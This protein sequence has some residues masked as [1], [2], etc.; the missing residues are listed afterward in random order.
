MISMRST[1]PSSTSDGRRAL[2]EEAPL[3]DL[4]PSEEQ[5]LIVETVHQFAENEVR[6]KARDCDES[7]KLPG[8]VLSQAHELGLVANALDEA[9]GGGGERSAVTAAL[10]TEE[11]AGGDLAIALAALSPALVALPVSDFGS[12]AQKQAILPAFTGDRFVPGSLA[13]LEPEFGADPM[14]PGT[15]ARRDGGDFVLDGAKCLVPWIEG[16]THVIVTATAESGPRAFVVPCEALEVSPERV[17]QLLHHRFD[18]EAFGCGSLHDFLPGFRHARDPLAEQF[19]VSSDL[20]PPKAFLSRAYHSMAGICGFCS[21]SCIPF[22]QGFVYTNECA[23][24]EAPKMKGERRCV[25]KNR[26]AATRSQAVHVSFRCPTAAA[27]W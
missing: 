3:I 6:P 21:G 2:L 23:V 22:A 9:Y 27:R 8:D 14:K 7:A 19:G 5:Q 1:P 26:I 13:L 11:R 17:R 25:S 20:A 10:V 24:T 18:R 4:E 12:D 15:R 16:G